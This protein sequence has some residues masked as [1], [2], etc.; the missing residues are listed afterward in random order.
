[1]IGLFNR[2]KAKPKE[3]PAA[4]W[5]TILLQALGC[6]AIAAAL[7]Q[8]LDA[9][10]ISLPGQIGAAHFHRLAIV[11]TASIVGLITVLISTRAHLLQAELAAGEQRYRLLFERSVTG[12]YRAALDGVILEC[13]AAFC[14]IFGYDSPDQ[15]CGRSASPGYFDPEHRS[16]FLRKLRGHESITNFEQC[17]RR[18]DGSPVWILNNARLEENEGAPPSITGT[19]TDITNLRVAEQEQRRL[20]AIVR[21]STDAI[22][23]STL[24]GVIETWNPGAERVFGYTPEQI[25]GKSLALLAPADRPAQWMEI[26][27]A[28]RRG[29]RQDI[30]TVRLRNDGTPV[31]IA[32]SVSPITNAMADVVGAVAI[33]RDITQAREA[34]AALRRSEAQYRLLFHGN[35]VP[36]WVFD[37]PTLRFLAVNQAAVRQYGFSEEEFLSMTVADIRPQETIP[38]LLD[39]IA[40]RG[41]GLR[42][43]GAWRHRRKDGSRIDVEI[44]CHDLEF[45]GTQAMLVAAFDVTDRNE[46]QE[47]ARIAEARYRAIFDHAVIGIFQAAPDGR[48]IIFN[49]ALAEMHGY[50]SA[51]ELMAEVTNVA[52][53]LFADPARMA[54][55][56][57]EADRNGIVRG[58]EAEL[59]CRDGSSKWGLINVRAVRNSDGAIAFFEGTVEDITERKAAQQQVQFL[60]WYD[61]L[62]RLPNRILLRDR[63]EQ[64]LAAARRSSE[65][66]ALL[67]LDLDRFKVIND[68]LGHSLGDLLLREVAVRL[69]HSLRE[70]DTVAR[71][72]GDEFVI[73]LGGLPDAA[74][75]AASATRILRLI[76]E[77]FVIPGHTLNTSCSIGISLFPDSGSD[78]ETLIRYA[79]Q[80]MYWVKENGRNN[81]RLFTEDLDTLAVAR[82]QLENDLRLALA[83]QEFF[84]VYQPEIEMGVGRM[85]AMEALIRWRHPSLGLIPPCDFIPIAESSGVIA[86]IGEWVLLTA[87]AQARQWQ[88]QGFGLVPVAV[89]VSAFQIR[90]QGFPDLVRQALRQTGLPPQFLELELTESVLLSNAD[91]IHSVLEDLRSIGVRLAIDD[92]GTGYSSLSYLKDFRVN[93]L[94]IDRSFVADLATDTDAAA[95]TAAIV[96]MARALNL[97]VVAEGVEN[98]AQIDFLHDQ[99]C[100]AIQ[101]YFCSRP[102]PSADIP[103]LFVASFGDTYAGQ[104]A[105]RESAR[106]LA[107][108]ESARQ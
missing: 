31:N 38:A 55:L 97:Q 22:L 84:L 20:A 51:Q 35:P 34:E 100:H 85:Y 46:A 98:K 70:Q 6:A 108:T 47:A 28:V 14:Q 79:D 89:N 69:R 93:K 7:L 58:A 30:E 9:I 64:A 107:P 75:A 12:A 44:V 5:K 103:P 63:L 49:R 66:V 81:V 86:A 4:P 83:R 61:P 60:A 57:Q 3:P 101:G 77:E 95:I 102:V 11:F 18:R 92:F 53:Q 59:A 32:L 87:C 1:M 24:E 27:D 65:K 56:M 90:R 106:E 94:K 26:L 41:N 76:T 16:D 50:S 15:I 42:G 88:L 2:R 91:V 29:H 104:L 99:G 36:M 45:H 21:C 17:L 82:L 8:V 25:I 80:A 19:I 62:T 78:C 39:D 13:N 48:P 40:L 52:V 96:A 43:A 37:P 72:G 54:E 71:V 73:V 23:S 105:P 67:F 33:A 74:V 10:H 68:S